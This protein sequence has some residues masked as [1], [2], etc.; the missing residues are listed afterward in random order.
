MS[1]I[2]IFIILVPVLV[3]IL[4]IVNILLAIHRPDSEKVS[5]YECGFSPVYSQTR[6]PF[7]ISFYLVGILFLVFDCELALSF[8]LAV[9]L[10][11]VNV[12]GYWI[13]TIFFVLLTIGFVYEFA[14]GALYFTEQRSSLSTTSTPIVN[15]ISMELPLPL[16]IP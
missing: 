2:I 4:L 10:Y 6:N 15:N 3:L 13:F 12:Y 14:S 7:H 8:P 1:A 9:S 5:P 11:E 16:I